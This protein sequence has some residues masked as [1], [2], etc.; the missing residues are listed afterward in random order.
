M[1][2]SLKKRGCVVDSIWR[3]KTW[4]QHDICIATLRV[5]FPG[6]PFPRRSQNQTARMLGRQGKRCRYIGRG[7]GSLREGIGA[8]APLIIMQ[9]FRW[10]R[11]LHLC[12][13]LRPPSM[14]A[15][16][17]WLG[18]ALSRN[19]YSWHARD[20]RILCLSPLGCQR[21]CVRPESSLSVS[22]CLS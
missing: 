4:A 13:S 8:P 3:E 21:P 7:C 12:S 19:A 10:C 2:D 11:I 16:W 6:W 1:G 22:L 14:A 18:T 9:P 15:A 17:F 20:T 5:R